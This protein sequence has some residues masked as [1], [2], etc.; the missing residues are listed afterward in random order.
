V[1]VG[2]GPAA[3]FAALF[4]AAVPEAAAVPAFCR[5]L[6]A[7]REETVLLGVLD[8]AMPEL[9]RLDSASAVELVTFADRY[10]GF[11]NARRFAD[12]LAA[13]EAV[14]P[15]L[16]PLCARLRLAREAAAAVSAAPL[17]EAG[18]AGPALGA[19]LLRRRQAAA[20]ALET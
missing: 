16:A 3:R 13:A 20:A 7:E 14:D 1:A 5:R 6:R 10:R 18:L 8:R 17:R 4:H 12:L 2:A 19:E 15:A 9:R 11:Q